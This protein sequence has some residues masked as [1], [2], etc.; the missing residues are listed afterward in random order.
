[1]E[2]GE[3]D[4]GEILAPAIRIAREGYP[5]SGIMAKELSTHRDR[6]LPRPDTAEIY[7][8]NGVLAREGT[9]VFQRDMADTFEDL[10]RTYDDALP[11]ER[12]RAIQAAR[13][14]FYRGPIA[15]AIV[16]FSEADNGY[17]TREDFSGFSAEIVEP[18]SSDYKGITVFQNPPN[19]Q[20]ISMLLALNILK[21]YDFRE[22]GAN[23]ADAIHLQAEA[24][25]LALADRFYHVGDPER[26]EVP[27]R[28]LLSETHANRQRERINM[29]SAMHWPIPDG[30]EPLTDDLA[31]TT[32]FHIVDK[33]GNGAAV[34]ASIGSQFLVVPDTGI[35]INH[36]M[37]F[38]SLRDGD[39]NTPAPNYKVRHTSN[40]YMAFRDD[41]L[42]IIGGNTG[43]D[44]QAQGQ[45]QQFIGAVE[46]GLSAEEAVSRPRFIGT[47]FPPSVHGYHPRNTLQLESGFSQ[48]TI[49]NLRAKGHDVVIDVGTYGYAG[50]III[51]EDGDVEVGADPRMDVSFGSKR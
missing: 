34:T 3:L 48:S 23:S 31:N 28:E 10:V 9:I 11:R 39:A 20:G 22:M 51:D 40:P 25:K 47:A 44:S 37:R 5:V 36:R 41:K 38:F 35:H 46:F 12:S 32:T 8:Q 33:E 21:D 26:I 43:A 16:D 13:D 4:L 49:D 1:M 2:Y 7:V 6:I 30:F 24:L 15:E 50:M 17:L 14:Y 45:V 27:T 19:S 29:S 42:Y 18:I